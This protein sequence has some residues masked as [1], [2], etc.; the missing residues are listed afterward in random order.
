MSLVRRI[1][2]RCRLG[3]LLG[4]GLTKKG[5]K[6]LHQTYLACFIGNPCL[7][8]YIASFVPVYLSFSNCKVADKMIILHVVA[9]FVVNSQFHINYILFSVCSGSSVHPEIQSSNSW[10]LHHKSPFQRIRYHQTLSVPDFFLLKD[11]NSR[12]NVLR[13]EAWDLQRSP[14]SGKAR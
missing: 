7:A 11:N 10:M 3:N 9:Y 4:E 5:D 14:I 12:L 13:T 2:S 8:N 6:R 1:R